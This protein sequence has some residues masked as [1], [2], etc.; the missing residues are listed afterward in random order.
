M[1]APIGKTLYAIASLKECAKN[2][3]CLSDIESDSTWFLSEIV[4][5]PFKVTA[6]LLST[7]LL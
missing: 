3:S 2:K 6:K 7:P 4:A 1:L 5:K